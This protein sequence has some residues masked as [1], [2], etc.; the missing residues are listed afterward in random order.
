LS[1]SVVVAVVVV[2]GGDDDDVWPSIRMQ[3]IRGRKLR[4]AQATQA[5]SMAA[6]WRRSCCASSDRG[7]CAVR[8]AHVGQSMMTRDFDHHRPL[9]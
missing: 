3:A 5:N 1:C 4:P 9:I 8:S 6:V 7:R 2:V